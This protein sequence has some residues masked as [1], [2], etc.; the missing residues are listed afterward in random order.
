MRPDNRHDLFP[1]DHG[2]ISDG[3]W[4]GTA[5]HP[6]SSRAWLMEPYS[7]SLLQALLSSLRRTVH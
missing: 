5:S 7:Q 4:S 3:V 2:G 6:I 1:V